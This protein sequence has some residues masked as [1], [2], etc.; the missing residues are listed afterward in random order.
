[1]NCERN[2]YFSSE[3]FSEY[4][5]SGDIRYLES[6]D[7]IIDHCKKEL[8]ETLEKYNFIYLIE[9]C[10]KCDFHIHTHTFDEILMATPE[11]KIYICE[12]CQN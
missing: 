4:K 5:V 7:D 9:K 12:G 11:D 3:T 6:L 10:N 8:L 1:M 2:F